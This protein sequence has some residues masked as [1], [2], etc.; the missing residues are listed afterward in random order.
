[1][2]WLPRLS[3]TQ[4]CSR[5]GTCKASGGEIDPPC[6]CNFGR[7]GSHCEE[8]LVGWFATPN[9]SLL[10]LAVGLLSAIAVTWRYRRNDRFPQNFLYQGLAPPSPDHFSDD[11]EDLV[12]RASQQGMEL[13]EPLPMPKKND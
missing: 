6:S 1:M 2:H 13:Q 12:D 4:H 8:S 3:I 11:E 5:H 7:R 9:G 10:A